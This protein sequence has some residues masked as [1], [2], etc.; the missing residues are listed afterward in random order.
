MTKQS[1]CD[2]KAPYLKLLAFM[3][4]AC[5]EQGAAKSDLRFQYLA[6]TAKM[7]R[8]FYMLLGTQL[9]GVDFVNDSDPIVIL[10]SATGT[11]TLSWSSEIFSCVM[12]VV[13]KLGQVR[14]PARP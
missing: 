12:C 14:Q 8:C 13:A 4:L 6:A 2:N 7:T 3:Y 10:V 11:M 9:Q 1:E 5:V